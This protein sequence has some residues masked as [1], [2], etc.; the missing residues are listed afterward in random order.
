MKRIINV[1]LI[2]SVLTISSNAVMSKE[3]TAEN[4][5][6]NTEKVEIVKLRPKG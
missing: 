5:T 4:K 1:C 2:C 6:K 3:I